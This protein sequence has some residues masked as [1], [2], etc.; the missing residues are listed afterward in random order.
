MYFMRLR[1]EI[2]L[3]IRALQIPKL[4]LLLLFSWDCKAPNIRAVPQGG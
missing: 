3:D 1:A 4:L 2:F